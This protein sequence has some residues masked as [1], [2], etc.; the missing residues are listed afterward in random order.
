[1]NIL[2]TGSTGLLGSALTKY[3][4]AHGH[5][6]YPLYRNP[7]TDKLHY[8]IPEENRIHL[9]ETITI[10]AVIHLAGENIADSRWTQKK[11]DTILNSRV[12]GTQLLAQT[13]A[14]MKQKPD[15]LISGSA[16]G[17]YGDT[18]NKIVDEDSSRGT[19]FLSDIAVQWEAAT[20]VAEDAG[21][22]TI[23]LRTGI[24]LSSEGGVL[25]KMSLPFSLGLGGIVG[26]G[27]Q[28]MSWISI[29]DVV[30]IIET[31]LDNK[32]MSG[33][34]NLVAPHPVTNYRFTKSLGSALHRPTVLPLPAFMV[35][36][37]FGEM[38]DTLLLSSSR[39]APTRL[40]SADYKFIDNELT[41]TMAKLL[42]K[43]GK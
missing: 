40:K 29:N 18:G 11:K 24:V 25:H 8:W 16:I 33:P 39:V 13:L 5:K 32:Q 3:L 27:Q 4:G 35:R 10:D 19:G 42:N 37:L 15:L 21:I 43:K 22:R 9:D 34:Y 41:G 26:N 38:G 36:L 12:R 2:L 6:I 31:M 14:S 28:Y 30:G 1:M 7:K 17:Y 20:K 23:H